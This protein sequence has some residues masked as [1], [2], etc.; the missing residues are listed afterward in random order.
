[1]HQIEHYELAQQRVVGLTLRAGCTLRVDHGRLWLTQPG[2]HQDIWLQAGESW[3][4]ATTGLVWLSA[5]PSA[6]FQLVH[7]LQPW[8]A[9]AHLRAWLPS[10]VR[11]RAWPRQ[12]IQV[13]QSS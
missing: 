1:M 6:Q 5:E 2:Q 9:L 8:P 11:R 3:T 12:T 7:L 4:Q 10:W 13:C